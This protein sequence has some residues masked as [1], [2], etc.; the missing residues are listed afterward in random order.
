[1]VAAAPSGYGK[2]AALESF[3]GARGDE[4]RTAWVNL[5]GSCNHP[6]RFWR[7]VELALGASGADVSEM[8]WRGDPGPEDMMFAFSRAVSSM[9]SGSRVALV[10][11]NF[12]VI[13]A[14]PLVRSVRDMGTAGM[15]NLT[16]FIAG[17]AA[18][19][20]SMNRRDMRA[21]V[22]AVGQDDLLF[23]E[24][25][26]LDWFCGIGAELTG[27]QA[28]KLMERTGGVAAELYVR[29]LAISSGAADIET[30]VGSDASDLI[31]AILSR[32]TPEEA[33]LLDLV[34]PLDEHPVGLAAEISGRA[35]A[36]CLLERAAGRSSLVRRLGPDEYAVSGI[37]SRF[38][39]RRRASSSRDGYRTTLLAAGDWYASRGDLHDC[40]ECYMKGGGYE[41]LAR[42][43]ER[44]FRMLVRG[45]GIEMNDFKRA[46]FEVCFRYIESIPLDL[47]RRAA[48]ILE[49]AYVFTLM[50]MGED[51][52]FAE[53]SAAMREHYTPL[54][55]SEARNRII[56]E[57][58][59]LIVPLNFDNFKLK[60]SAL[61]S[62]A[63]VLNGHSLYVKYYSRIALSYPSMLLLFY[64]DFKPLDD[65]IEDY[66][67]RME[68]YAAVTGGMM[69]G[70]AEVM[71]GEV[72]Y[73]R[74]DFE[75]AKRLAM[76][77][78]SRAKE[79]N[80]VMS[81]T[82]LRAKVSAAEGDLDR[83]LA[84]L[85]DIM[86]AARGDDFD[87]LYMTSD[88]C[89]AFLGSIMRDVRLVPGWIAEGVS[90]GSHAK[91]VTIGLK[92]DLLPH[93]FWLLS[94]GQYDKLRPLAHDMSVMFERS[95]SRMGILYTRIA[96]A[97]LHHAE[98]NL[99]KARGA[100]VTAWRIASPEGLVMPFVE[101]SGALHPLVQALL[102]ARYRDRY[103]G[104]WLEMLDGRMRAFNR[105]VM[106]LRRKY[107]VRSSN[108]LVTDFRRLD[109]AA[110]EMI[111]GGVSRREIRDRL[112][113]SANSLRA[114]IVR[115][116]GE[117]DG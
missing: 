72:A 90:F 56:G 94:S 39:R 55:E 15:S 28:A 19:D 64:N 13:R 86:D 33:C 100:L 104:K 114:I 79:R 22:G 106:N 4:F 78:A 41:A 87:L 105:A 16:I 108:G 96:E 10:L 61:E 46:E 37:L 34:S 57:L 101:R 67:E 93:S 49:L 97:V 31:E 45:T 76:T 48:P 65:L 91:G 80:V 54:P 1:V 11:D 82:Y 73:E 52:K 103:F 85:R 3:L 40:C 83:S 21:L 98:G 68:R 66:A 99:H 84:R 77:A 20:F 5:T 62:A 102:S 59:M 50:L 51:D 23:K 12:H 69:T 107:Y 71:N 30:A 95:N 116:C 44:P 112:G 74:G 89:W 17:R 115:L 58:D 29:S 63:N 35:D 24:A 53:R 32:H 9:G 27:P 38:L 60:G 2:T 8:A 6:E 88:F 92:L 18:P 42:V 111:E 70:V 47:L 110:R 113:L 117:R 75:T 26:A 36:G 7:K 81:A 14:S 43:L 109:A 25:E